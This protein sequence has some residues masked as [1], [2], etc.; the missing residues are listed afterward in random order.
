MNTSLLALP[1]ALL[2]EPNLDQLTEAAESRFLHDPCGLYTLEVTETNTL[3]VIADTTLTV[4]AE[5]ELRDGRWTL[6]SHT[7]TDPGDGDSMVWTS[8]GGQDIPFVLP[9]LGT[10]SEE[11]DGI[12][13]E[14][15]QL[16]DEAVRLA[17]SEVGADTAGIEVYDGREHYRLDMLLGGG[18][19][20][21]RGREDNTAQVVVDPESLRAREWRLSI[22]DPTRMAVGRLLFL[23]ANLRVDA[24][25]HPLSESLR[26]K[27]RLGPFGLEVSRAITYTRTGSCSA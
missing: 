9:L 3:G 4:R 26:T 8:A 18:W 23:E 7:I 5:A 12:A 22:L 16:L 1:L 14:G 21:L 25:G 11:E 24:V 27:A 13:S 2:P 19:T 20:L 17:R 15:R 10:F 6:L